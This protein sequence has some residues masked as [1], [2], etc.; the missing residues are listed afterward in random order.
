MND[1]RKITEPLAAKILIFN[2]SYGVIK[3]ISEAFIP[4]TNKDTFNKAFNLIVSEYHELEKAIQD[5]N[6]AEIL[7]ALGDII[8]LLYGLATRMGVYCDSFLSSNTISSPN[9]NQNILKTVY[10]SITRLGFFVGHPDEMRGCVIRALIVC[11]EILSNL[12][13]DYYEVVSRI[14]ERNMHKFADTEEEA[15]ASV[16]HYKTWVSNTG[17]S[18]KTPSYRLAPDGKRWVIYDIET[19]KVLK[20]K[21]WIP[22]DLS[23]L[24]LN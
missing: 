16:E 9:W 20:V 13:V 3:D 21:G 11:F 8:Y 5:N 10:P 1:L 14:H 2:W 4:N 22:P 17:E 7:D 18:Y 15:H 24:I 6:K 12:G 19:K 23:D